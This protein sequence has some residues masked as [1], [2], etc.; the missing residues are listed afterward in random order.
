DQL[1]DF[2]T[3]DRIILIQPKVG[4]NILR[5]LLVGSNFWFTYPPSV[6]P[7]ETERRYVAYGLNGGDSPSPKVPF[8][9][10]DYYIS[11][12]NVPSL[13]ASDTGVLRKAVMSHSSNDF[14][15]GNLLPLLDCVADFQVIFG[16]DMNEDGVVG[17]FSTPDGS[18]ISTNEGSSPSNVTS[19]MSD[20]EAIRKR[21]KEIRVYILAH[22]GGIDMNFNY[23]SSTIEVGDFGLGKTF[24]LTT[25]PNYQRYRWKVLKLFVKP[26]NF[27]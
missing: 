12:S 24:D 7:S 25:I 17:T 27:R 11:D 14:P 8:N 4:E 1:Q 15:S 23:P 20:A 22:E 13:C 19:T 6:S 5:R 18:T 16:F 26:K 9:R 10:A 21:L 3:G 2:Q